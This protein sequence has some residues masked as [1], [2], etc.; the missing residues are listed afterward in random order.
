MATGRI[1]QSADIISKLGPSQSQLTL[2][3]SPD[4]KI[5][6]KTPKIISPNS[7]FSNTICQH[8]KFFSIF[9]SKTTTRATVQ[10]VRQTIPNEL[11]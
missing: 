9:V 11:Y 6:Q 4:S 2:L 1:N 7:P 5:S 3:K 8:T 10:K